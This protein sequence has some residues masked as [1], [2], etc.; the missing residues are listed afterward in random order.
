[1]GVFELLFCPR[2]GGG[3]SGLELTDT[4]EDGISHYF[5]ELIPSPSHKIQ[6][7]VTR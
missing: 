3:W 6:D 1:M 7:C 4:Q 5:A 2:G